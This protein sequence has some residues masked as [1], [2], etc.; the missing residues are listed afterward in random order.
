M[1]EIRFILKARDK[2]R[3]IPV[4]FRHQGR[5]PRRHRHIVRVL[6]QRIK[7]RQEIGLELAPVGDLVQ[8]P[9]HVA[10]LHVVAEDHVVFR[11][12]AQGALLIQEGGSVHIAH[13]V[14][15]MIHIIAVLPLHHHKI[16]AVQAVHLQPSRGVRVHLHQLREPLPHHLRGGH[17]SQSGSGPRCANHRSDHGL[18]FQCFRALRGV[19][20]QRRDSRFSRDGTV[21]RLRRHLRARVLAHGGRLG[22]L[23]KGS[24]PLL[25]LPVPF[26]LKPASAKAHSRIHKN[27]CQ[28]DDRQ[29]AGHGIPADAFCQKAPYFFAH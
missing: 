25:N 6:V 9:E 29:P 23:A 26:I 22:T 14:K 8:F 28:A 24:I 21:P 5:T 11:V 3:K 1:V 27:A 7:M 15:V 10:R 2:E 20:R 4:R 19:L 16:D 17:G 12:P 18:G 13:A